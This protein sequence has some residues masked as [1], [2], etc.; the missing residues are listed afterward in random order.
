MRMTI[1]GSPSFSLPSVGKASAT[2]AEVPAATTRSNGLYGE[3]RYPA[4]RSSEKPPLL[5]V[6]TPSVMKP[7][8][9]EVCVSVSLPTFVFFG[10]HSAQNDVLGMILPEHIAP[11]PFFPPHRIVN[12]PHLFSAGLTQVCNSYLNDGKFLVLESGKF[13]TVISRC[14]RN[15]AAFAP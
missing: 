7:S 15:I 9:T 12:N 6:S 4:S 3:P 10:R 14:P 1:N 5:N 8:H 11:H 13:L 2:A